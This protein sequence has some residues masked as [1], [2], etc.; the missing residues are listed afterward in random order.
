MCLGSCAVISAVNRPGESL[1]SDDPLQSEAP[2]CGLSLCFLSELYEVRFAAAAFLQNRINIS[3]LHSS[4]CL[5]EKQQQQEK[6]S[7]LVKI[8]V[9]PLSLHLFSAFPQSL[10]IF[11]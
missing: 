9:S 5:I 7:C 10:H 3:F 6:V 4:L 8:S 2:Q 1:P 11:E